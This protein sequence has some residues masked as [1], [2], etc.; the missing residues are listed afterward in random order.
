MQEYKNKSLRELQKIIGENIEEHLML[1]LIYHIKINFS[2]YTIDKEIHFE[3]GVFVLLSRNNNTKIIGIVPTKTES[4]YGERLCYKNSYLSTFDEI[5]IIKDFTDDTKHFIHEH[6]IHEHFNPKEEM[7][8]DKSEIFCDKQGGVI[9]YGYNILEPSGF[10]S[11]VI[12][13]ENRTRKNLL[14]NYYIMFQSF[15]N[16]TKYA[17]NDEYRCLTNEEAVINFLIDS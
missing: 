8:K 11:D 1:K 9:V 4:I 13:K 14:D 3:N 7:P 12:P 15:Y 17:G 6:F 2:N 10:Y 16:C 5:Y